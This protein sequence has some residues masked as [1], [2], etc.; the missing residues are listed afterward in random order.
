[1]SEEWRRYEELKLD[2]V[3][4]AAVAAFVET[5]YHGAT[6]R[7]I[8]QLAGLSVPGMYHHFATKQ[9]MLVGILDLTM[10]DLLQRSHRAKAEAGG[11]SVRAFCLLVECLVLFHCYRRDL[12]FIGASEMRSLESA[13]R[14]RIASLRTAQ[15]RLI[16][17]EVDQAH[18]SGLFRVAFPRDAAR[19]V[20]TMCT[21]IP[22][23]YRMG[24]ESTPEEVADRYVDFALG[25]MRYSGTRPR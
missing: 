4:R 10:D 23:W 11:D 5:G 18:T 25:M 8:A 20:T 9:D 14:A 19:A 21:A 12:G 3:L 13:N 7:K 2:P 17:A 24:Q 22:S 1:M 6:V 16:D 15:Q